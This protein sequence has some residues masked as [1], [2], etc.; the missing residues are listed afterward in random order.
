MFLMRAILLVAPLLALLVGSMVYCVLAAV[1]AA[2]YLK[3]SAAPLRTWP[4]ISVLRPLAGAHDNTEANLRSVFEQRYPNFEVLLSVHEESDPA[5]DL[6]RRVM[7][8]Y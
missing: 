5:A 3:S 6:A 8:A 4:A 2:R 1:G 7:A